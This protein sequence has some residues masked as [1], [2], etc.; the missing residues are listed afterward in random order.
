MERIINNMLY[1]MAVTGDESKPLF[2]AICLIVSV[3]LM[4]VLIVT[5]TVMSKRNKDDDTDEDQGEVE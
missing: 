2:V 3:I 4:V 1:L 5:G